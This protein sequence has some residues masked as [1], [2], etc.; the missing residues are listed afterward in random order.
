MQLRAAV[1]VRYAADE[2][3]LDLDDADTRAAEIARAKT[4]QALAKE[5]VER[6]PHWKV[7]DLRTTAA[8]QLREYHDVTAE[9]ASLL[10]AHTRPVREG[11]AEIS[12][13]YDRSRLL[14]PR[15]AALIAWAA[16]L[17]ALAA[18]AAVAGLPAK[19][20]P[21]GPRS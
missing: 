18:G 9:V 19:V 17:E 1:D 6:R 4:V 8:T 12:R 14:A 15:R 3:G 11:A 10:L 20:L 5:K 21:M 13:V 16:W 7:H 2:L